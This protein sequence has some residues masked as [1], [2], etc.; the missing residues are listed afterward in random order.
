MLCKYLKRL[1][2]EV[3]E[4]LSSLAHQAQQQSKSVLRKLSL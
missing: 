2:I 1:K 4:Y 3:G